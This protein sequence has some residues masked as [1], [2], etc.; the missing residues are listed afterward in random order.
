M[1]LTRRKA[2]GGIAIG[3]AAV[4]AGLGTGAFSSVEADRTLN[5]T[6]ADD[7]NALLSLEPNE[8]TLSQPGVSAEDGPGNLDPYGGDATEYV[9]TAGG[10]VE[11]DIANLTDANG[12]N[13][14][15]VTRF[16]DLIRV[17]NNGTQ[18]VGVRVDAPSGVDVFA[19]QSGGGTVSIT[20]GS[21]DVTLPQGTIGGVSIEVDTTGISSNLSG[22]TVTIFADAA[23]A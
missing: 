16:D 6:L 21:F 17:Q 18:D 10:E 19:W 8:G 11:I 7:A 3:A 5:V 23:Q 14:N 13:D 1:K 2:L 12:V 20:G 22:A 9:N 4:G 15:A